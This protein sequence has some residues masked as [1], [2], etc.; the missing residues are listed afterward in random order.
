M[1][2][3]TEFSVERFKIENHKWKHVS[4]YDDATVRSNHTH[5]LLDAPVVMLRAYYAEPDLAFK[6]IHE[7]RWDEEQGFWVDADNDIALERLNLTVLSHHSHGHGSEA[8]IGIV[9][10]D[11]DYHC[12]IE[13]WEV[14]PRTA[15]AQ[16]TDHENRVA[17]AAKAMDERVPAWEHRLKFGDEVERS[18]PT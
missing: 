14:F 13:K 15:E 10:S 11:L 2:R 16:S 7:V 9:I 17:K 12:H 1:K 18:N 4:T 5:G 6:K 3:Y 8:W